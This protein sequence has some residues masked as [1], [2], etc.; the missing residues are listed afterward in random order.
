MITAVVLS[1]SL[2]FSFAPNLNI[3]LHQTSSDGT[4]CVPIHGVMPPSCG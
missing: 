4:D 1:L 2:L 3:A